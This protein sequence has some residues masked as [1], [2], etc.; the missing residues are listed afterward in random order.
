MVV[1]Q[2]SASPL[3]LCSYAVVV[4]LL[5]RGAIALSPLFSKRSPTPTL[6]L[7]STFSEEGSL[8]AYRG[9]HEIFTPTR[10][11]PPMTV[12][13]LADAIAS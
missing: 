2:P 12:K 10:T 11:Y 5:I 8:F 3:R 4:T 6:T 1:L 7:S 9:K 13:E